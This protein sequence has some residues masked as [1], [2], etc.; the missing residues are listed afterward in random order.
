MFSGPRSV[1]SPCL[2]SC[3]RLCPPPTPA[4]SLSF[5]PCTQHGNHVMASEHSFPITSV[6]QSV[7]RLPGDLILVYCFYSLLDQDRGQ[8]LEK[9]AEWHRRTLHGPLAQP[10]HQ[11]CPRAASS[12]IPLIFQRKFSLL[13][14][15]FL[16][17]LAFFHFTW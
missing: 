11:D 15:R 1:S 3:L 7:L 8:L 12:P 17:T 6:L 4:F 14:S 10:S 9:I 2:P 5:S 16:L 13:A